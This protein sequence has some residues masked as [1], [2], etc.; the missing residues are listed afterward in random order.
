MANF[1]NIKHEIDQNVNTNGVQ[2][3]TGAILNETLKDMIDEVDS[4]KQ[5]TLVAGSGIAINGNVISATGGSGQSY[6]AGEGI[7][8]DP[9][10]V[11]SVD[12]SDLAGDGLKE[13]SN[14]KLAVDPDEFQEKLTAGANIQISG[15]T[16]SA[17]D[18]TYSAGQGLDLNGTTFSVDYNEVQEK[19][20]SGQNIK[21]VNGYSLLGSGDIVI[22]GGGGGNYLPLEGGTLQNTAAGEDTELKVIDGM[23]EDYVKIVAPESQ[24]EEPHIEIFE[25]GSGDTKI[26]YDHIER[27]AQTTINYPSSSGTLALTSDIPEAG[28]GL[29]ENASGEFEV[30]TT[31]IQEK[32]VA[33]QNI[34]IQGN[35]ISASGG[36]GQSYVAGNGI[37]IT[38][39]TISVDNTVATTSDLAGYLP[40]TGG[41]LRADSLST[42]LSIKSPSNDST[43]FINSADTISP[44]IELRREITNPTIGDVKEVEINQERLDIFRY[45]TGN[46]YRGDSLYFPQFKTGTIALDTDLAGKQDTLVAGANITIQGNVIS[47]T[48][49]GSGSYVAGN[50]INISGSTISVD[51][52]YLDGEYLPLSGGLLKADPNDAETLL[53]IAAPDDTSAISMSADTI[54]SRLALSADI[55]DSGVSGGDV[56]RTVLSNNGRIQLDEKT[57]DPLDPTS[58]TT[59]SYTLFLPQQNDIIATRSDISSFQLWTSG[60]GDNSLLGPQATISGSSATATGDGA[61]SVGRD[62][63]ATANYTFAGGQTCTAAGPSSISYGRGTKTNSEGEA[64]LGKYNSSHIYNGTA[65]RNYY[66]RFS[67]GNGSSTVNTKNS[68]EVRSDDKVFVYGLGGYQGDGNDTTSLSLQDVVNGKQDTLVAGQN[69]TIQNNVIS[70]SGGSGSGLWVSGEGT[71]S[72]KAPA[73][74]ADP[75]ASTTGVGSLSSGISSTHSGQTRSS[76]TQGDYAV[77]F[78]RG[79]QVA[80]DYAGAIG[81]GNSASGDAGFAIGSNN[82]AFGNA[83][84]AGGSSSTAGGS[85]D[86]AF[87]GTTGIGGNNVAINGT[88]NGTGYHNFALNGEV[89]GSGSNPNYSIAIGRRLGNAGSGAHTYADNSIAIG[90]TTDGAHS[91]AIGGHTI[92]EYEIGIGPYNKTYGSNDNSVR[93]SFTVGNGSSVNG[94]TTSRNVIEVKKNDDLYVSGVGG[95]DGTNS[96]ASDTLQ[97]VLNGK[98]DQ[99]TA[100]TGISIQG[101]VISATGG[102][103]GSSYSAGPGITINQNNEISA[104]PD[105]INIVFDSNDQLNLE[106]TSIAGN[107]Q[108]TGLQVDSNTGASLEV[109]F[110]QIPGNIAGNGLQD[111][112]NGLLEIDTSQIAG[113]GLQDSGNGTLEIDITTIASDLSGNFLPLTGGQLQADPS[114]AETLLDVTAPD[115]TSSISM[116]A[117]TIDSKLAISADIENAGISDG[118]T[119]RTVFTNTGEI[120]VNAKTVNPL[121]P[122]DITPTTYTLVLPQKNDTIATLSDIQ[123]GGGSSYTA[124]AGINIDSNNVISNTAP[125]PGLFVATSGTNGIRTSNAYNTS[126]GNDA[127]ALGSYSKTTA[128]NSFAIGS[129]SEATGIE[130]M[131]FGQNSKA[132]AQGQVSIGKNAGPISLTTGTNSL[133]LGYYSE[134]TNP[135]EIAI[136]KANKSINTGTTAEK[137]QFT[138]GNGTG[139]NARSNLIEAKQNN[140]IYVYGVGGFNGTNAGQSGVETLQQAIANAGGGG[141]SYTAGQAIDITNGAISVDYGSGLGL[142]TNSELQVEW[143]EG[144]TQLAGSGLSANTQTGQLDVDFTSVQGKLT[145]GS[146]ITISG[147]TISAT[148][149]GGSSLWTSGTGT[150]SVMSPGANQANGNNSISAG[151][152]TRSNGTSSVALGGST[153]AT[154]LTSVAIGANST[155]AGSYS[156]ALGHGLGAANTD[157]TAL[158]KYNNN[159]STGTSNEKTFFTIGNGTGTNAKSNLIEAKENS[160]IYVYGI[161]GFDGTNSSGSQTLQ[162]VINN[163]WILGGGQYSLM[164]PGATSASGNYSISAGYD[165]QSNANYSVAIAGGIC[166][167]DDSDPDT[168]VDGNHGVAICE[169]AIVEGEYGIAI[170]K[171]AQAGSHSLALGEDTNSQGYKCVAVAGGQTQIGNYNFGATTGVAEGNYS[172]ALAGGYSVGEA[173]LAMGDQSISTSYTSVALGL[174]AMTYDN[175]T[176]QNASDPNAGEIAVGRYNYS[177]ENFVF[178][179]GC[180]IP[181]TSDPENSVRQNAITITND[182]KIFLKG[183]GGYTGTS[184]SGCTDLVSFLNNL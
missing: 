128:S 173:S 87:N 37:D 178:S 34:T 101:N 108:G 130:S 48:G 11:I 58:I 156:V 85:D 74:A 112:G 151:D 57:V 45:D 24:G 100:G 163:S 8:I 78:G 19:L 106:Y 170:G 107:L 70:A 116:S 117:D 65:P 136:G 68:F 6:T 109:D 104:N 184:V 76:L 32:L 155:A 43:V 18:T 71:N 175:P 50:G 10:N 138:V 131:C 67:I 20:E 125:D 132:R 149:G 23:D 133:C 75:N 83:S 97:D 7:D 13:D 103:G 55:N 80:G 84:F 179:V 113:N 82:S 129:W 44:T 115:T 126:T 21:T 177:D 134:A 148:G 16:I 30:D 114:D 27:G 91:I 5:D 53:D 110:S 181:D 161:G 124:G 59:T 182:G 172:V 120:Q 145:A 118:D 38:G 86:F 92:N 160:D 169:G 123:G 143:S 176:I 61:I 96:A 12:A 40:L 142:G 137:T 41:I 49:G 56:Y 164:S 77:N 144:P 102:G 73:T 93:T 1:N 64:A 81:S 135:E 54:D 90:G 171:G 36:S 47:A 46:V 72:L 51:E 26:Y 14:G 89:G 95:F 139:M 154:G 99:L 42:G 62:T 9:N 3:I 29:I 52:N 111:D 63:K 79:N 119:F 153:T 105:G 4:K 127:I 165:S 140:D 35:V 174:G 183:L 141:T 159:I 17:T 150:G 66:T 39:N 147:N 122:T 146:G 98:Q 31:A 88:I 157:E 168:I 166:A 22:G 2:A 69:I 152:F 60:V 33:G 25:N 28:S 94:Q 167:Y 158:G 121:D 162:D 180:G 15:S